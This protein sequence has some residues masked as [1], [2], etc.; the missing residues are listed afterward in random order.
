MPK[1][2]LKLILPLIIFLSG[3][4]EFPKIKP[5]LRCVNV[6]LDEVLVDGVAYRSGYCRCHLYEWNSNRIGKVG[7]SED[8]DQL[9]CNKLVGFEPDSWEK[10]VTWWESIRLYLIRQKK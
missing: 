6:F 8:Y 5:Q 7:P 1:L 2:K 4:N 3:C 10:I 9:K